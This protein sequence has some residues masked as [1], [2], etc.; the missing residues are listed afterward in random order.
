MDQ[1][2]LPE[3]PQSL[4]ETGGLKFISKNLYN[5]SWYNKQENNFDAMYWILVI[6][7][8]VQFK[9]FLEVSSNRHG[10]FFTA[11]LDVLE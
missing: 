1:D 7:H 10:Q 8:L 4:T 6:L 3:A 9:S 5:K 11:R 2:R